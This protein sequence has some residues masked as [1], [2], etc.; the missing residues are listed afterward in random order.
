V[1]LFV[2]DLYKP[3]SASEI[4]IKK[5]MQSEASGQCF[6]RGD[7]QSVSAAP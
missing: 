7:F 3:F 6:V 2:I 1:A 4:A 5:M